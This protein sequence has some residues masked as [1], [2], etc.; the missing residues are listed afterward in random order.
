M[1]WEESHSPRLPRPLPA[2]PAGEGVRRLTLAGE[3][4]HL[5]DK[6]AG[7]AEK[8]EAAPLI[9]GAEL[10]HLPDRPAGVGQQRLPP[11]SNYS[12]PNSASYSF[13]S[14]STSSLRPSGCTSTCR[15]APP[16]SA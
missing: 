15:V 13:V 2:C 16:S 3:L 4:L 10:L 5:P 11:S 6:P 7:V 9:L 14:V 12:E 1:A 8:R